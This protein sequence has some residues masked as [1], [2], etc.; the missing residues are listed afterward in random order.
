MGSNRIKEIKGAD[1]VVFL[2]R[3]L[4]EIEIDWKQSRLKKSVNLQGIND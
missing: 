1:K 3:F 4:I 2:V